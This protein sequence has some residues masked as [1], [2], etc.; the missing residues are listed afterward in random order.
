MPILG[1]KT[2]I[3]DS[4]NAK[5]QHMLIRLKFKNYSR[6][7][8][9]SPRAKSMFQ[10]QFSNLYPLQTMEFDDQDLQLLNNICE[11]G[12]YLEDADDDIRNQGKSLKSSV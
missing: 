4:C 2:S 3:S 9:C 8:L 10:V 6:P 7:F 11:N 5:L 1:D 12:N